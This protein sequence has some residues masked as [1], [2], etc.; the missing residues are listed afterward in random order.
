MENFTRIENRLDR[1]LLQNNRQHLEM[2]KY[3]YIAARGADQS[4]YSVSWNLNTG[5]EQESLERHGQTGCPCHEAP[6]VRR[7]PQRERSRS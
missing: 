3:G 1:D 7:K 6:M 2:S 5:W 4:R